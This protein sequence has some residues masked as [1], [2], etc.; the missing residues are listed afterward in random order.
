MNALGDVQE[1]I[2]VFDYNSRLLLCSVNSSFGCILK[3]EDI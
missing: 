3:L 2:S 1:L